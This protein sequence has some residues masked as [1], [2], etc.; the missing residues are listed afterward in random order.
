MTQRLRG[1]IVGCGYFAQFQLAAW[2]R[3]ADVEMVAASDLDADRARAAAPHA[4]TDA[5]EM[6]DREA[7]DF[8]DIATRPASHLELVRLT[9]GRGIPTICQKPMAASWEEAQE[10]ARLAQ[11]TSAPLVIHENWRWQPW[12]REARRLMQAGSIG[13]PVSYCF[14]TRQRDGL[15]DNAYARQPY[16]REMPRMLIYETVVHHIDTARFLFGPIESLYARVRRHNPNIRGEDCVLVVARHAGEVDGVIDGHRFL[17][18]E[19]PGPAMGEA[20]IDGDEAGLRINA[21]GEVFRGGETIF[22]PPAELGYKGDSVFATQ[23]HF[24]DCLR[25]GA[26]A[27]SEARAYLQTFAAVEAAYRSVAEH[28]EV[29]PGEIL[30]QPNSV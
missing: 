3:M 28:R 12:Y 25:A 7:L 17:D 22:T 23:R 24:I 20:W 13:K 27:E 18:P 4:Y 14:R 19:P 15:G 10:M 16:F 1:A 29:R 5:A 9:L 11:A 8:V 30:P 21:R 26:A 2:K 6:L